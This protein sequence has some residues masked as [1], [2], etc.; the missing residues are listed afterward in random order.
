MALEKRAGVTWWV[1]GL[2]RGHRGNTSNAVLLHA[3]AGYT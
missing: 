3:G 2:M 1:G